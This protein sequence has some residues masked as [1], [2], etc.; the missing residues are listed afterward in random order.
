MKIMISI[1]ICISMIVCHKADIK[2]QSESEVYKTVYKIVESTHT[3]HTKRKADMVVE[4]ARKYAL[5]PL[6]VCRLGYYESTYRHWLENKSSGSVG[7]MQ[8]IP[9]LWQHLVFYVEDGKYSEAVSKDGQYKK[10]MKYIG[11]NIEIGCK[12][13]KTYLDEHKN[14]YDAI[15]RYG[16]WWSSKY[17]NN[18]K[19][20]RYINNVLYRNPL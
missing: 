14:Y 15:R 20:E 6:I 12:I 7:I 18:P 8:P 11:C 3:G 4:K 5:D 1:L 19:M 17:D 16:G 2:K 9:A 10:Y 13:L